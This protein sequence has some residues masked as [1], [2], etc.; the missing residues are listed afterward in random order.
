MATGKAS[1]TA[2]TA[3]NSEQI[4]ALSTDHISALTTSDAVTLATDFVTSISTDQIGAL[5]MDL[6]DAIEE[7]EPTVTRYSPPSIMAILGEAAKEALRVGNH[8]AHAALDD[9][10]HTLHLVKLKATAALDVVDG[11]SHE[12]LAALSQNL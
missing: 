6:D 2:A 1:K 5:R 7:Y 3:L 10:H 12:I 8:P 4:A 9:L 11:E